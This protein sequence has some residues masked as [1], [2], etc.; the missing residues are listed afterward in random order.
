MTGALQL[1]PLVVGLYVAR[2]VLDGAGVVA[3]PGWLPLAATAL[4]GVV[5]VGAGPVLTW[6]R[7]RYAIREDAIDLRHGSFIVR[8]TVVPMRR[9]QHVE[10]STGPLQTLF[11]LASVTFHTAAGPVEI[12]ALDRGDA[13]EVRRQVTAL[14]QVLDDV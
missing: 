13:D 2:G 14:A 9:V 4:A 7:W 10:T 3:L 6:R 1:V 11:M 12:P 5:V 8:R